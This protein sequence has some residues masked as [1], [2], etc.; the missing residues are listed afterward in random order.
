MHNGKLYLVTGGAGFIG[1]CFV[2]G[3]VNAGRARVVTLDKLT[4]SG[5]PHNLDGLENRDLHDFVLGDIGDAELVGRLLRRY[6]PDAVI[7]FAAETH[8]DRSIADPAPFVQSNVAGLCALLGSTLEWWR[9][10]PP[11]KAAAFRFLHISTDEVFGTLKPGDPA[12]TEE[13]PYAPNSPY[14][15]S[16]ASSDHFCRAFYETY[17]LPV[18]ITNCSN[19]YGPRQF[20][21]KLIPLAIVNAL[22]GRP[23]PI[24]GSGENIRD[25]L[26]VEDHCAALELALERGRPGQTY[27][28]GGK[29]ERSNLEVIRTLC[30]LLDEAR[31]AQGGGGY[32]NLITH[33]TDRPGHDFRYAINCGKIERELGWRPA[34]S[35]EDGLRR[36]L[37]WYLENG[38]WLEQVQS[39]E[40]RRWL[41]HN[42]HNR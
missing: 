18:I 10:L 19:N 37:H 41:E 14:S 36:T 3:A 38:A 28:I 9:S 15:A 11:D 22:A 7:N 26:Y 42:Y 29:S 24:Y 2:L 27:N 39:G 25:W 35:F 4:Y 17:G 13:T 33:V 5:N 32:A 34:L 30:A 40:Y 16:K 12:F 31:P 6:R 21:E 1:S 8:V 23:I 20:P